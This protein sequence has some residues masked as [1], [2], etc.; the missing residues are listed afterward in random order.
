MAYEHDAVLQEKRHRCSI[1]KGQGF[2]LLEYAYL[3]QDCLDNRGYVWYRTHAIGTC[4][5]HGG[6]IFD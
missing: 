4:F 2:T 5:A 1:T 6:R 3:W